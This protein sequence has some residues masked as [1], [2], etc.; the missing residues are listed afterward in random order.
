MYSLRTLGGISLEGPSGPLSGRVVQARQVALLAVLAAAGNKGCT[1]DKLIGYL[2]PDTTQE[3][4]RHLLANAVYVLRQALGEEAVFSAGDVL[5]LNADAVRSDAASFEA[6]LASAHREEAV[7][8]YGGPFLEGFHISGTA[9]FERWID[10]ERQRLALAYEETLEAL[11]QAAGEVQEF[12]RAVSW[13]R[14]LANHDPYNSRVAQRLMKALAAAGD[15]ANAVQHAQ[16]HERLLKTE[17]GMEP[18]AELRELAEQL[19]AGPDTPDRVDARD[20]TRLGPPVSGRTEEAGSPGSGEATDVFPDTEPYLSAGR[21]P[22]AVICRIAGGDGERY[23]VTRRFLIGRAEGDVVQPGDPFLSSRHAEVAHRGSD[24]V[25]R[26]LGSL[27]GTFVRIEGVTPLEPGNCIMV[28]SQILRY[29]GRSDTLRLV[30]VDEGVEVRSYP[31]SLGDT[32]IGRSA[33]DISF[34]DDLLLS[35]L[36]ARISI[37]SMADTS[38]P[39]AD[40]DF[41][42]TVEDLS[43][44]GGVYRQIHD[45][46]RLRDGDVF[47]A[48]QQVFRFERV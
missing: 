43:G 2:W 23:A 15:P 22:Q 29:E 10:G 48:G 26:D 13:W 19:R 6:A 35:P 27:N 30:R 41:L 18:P 36:H 45:E 39:G 3:S 21:G 5:R 25:L 7:D 11:A 40:E 38:G 16:E 44:S 24:Y 14:R 33:D 47:A 37:R 31:L 28:G 17:F 42:T 9:E 32:H 12:E 8:L 46:W 20:T 1:R 34:P 4:A